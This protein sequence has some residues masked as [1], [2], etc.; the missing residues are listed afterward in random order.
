MKTVSYQVIQTST[1]TVT[2][3]ETKFDENFM[4]EFL[5]SFY[6]FQTLDDH[7]KHL[8]QLEARGLYSVGGTEFIEGY[9]PANEMGIEAHVSDMDLEIETIF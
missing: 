4:S 7:M 9:G 8:A 3:D 6:P 1:V 5:E 2:V